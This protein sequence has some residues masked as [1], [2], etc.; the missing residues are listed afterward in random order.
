MTHPF[1]TYIQALGKGRRGSRDLS[2][3]E[4]HEAMQMILRRQVSAEQIG[5]FLMLMRIKEETPQELAGLV[6]A[7]R[8]EVKLPENFP[9]VDLDW[10]CYAGK[11]RQLPWLALSVMLLAQRGIKV[12]LHGSHMPGRIGVG[13][14]LTSL[15]IETSRDC[16]D[17]A[18]QLTN[19]NLAYLPLQ[20]LSPQLQGLLELKSTLG[21]RSPVNSV[22]R[23]LNPAGAET[24][25]IGIFHPGYDLAHQAAAELLGDKRSAVFKGEGG[26][27]ERN[28]D[29]DCTIRLLLDGVMHE[30]SWPAIFE[31]RHLKDESMDVGRLAK[32]WRGEI[33][34]E[35]A[36]S[37]V[38]ATAAIALRA[39]DKATDRSH[40]E[41]L[42]HEYWLARDRDVVPAFAANAA[43]A[44][45][46][47]VALVGAGPG[48]PELL[49]LRAL[50]LLQHADVV[51]YDNLVAPSILAMSNTN[52]ETI[53]VGKR[54]ANHALP[55]EQINEMLVRL[56]MQGKRVVRLKGG[57]PF[58]FGRGGEEIETLAEHHVPFE[59]VP[60]ITAASGVAAYAGIPLT[61][62]DH[63]QSCVFVTGHLKDGSMDLDW[64]A[65]S[66]PNQTIVVYMGLQGVATLCAQLV[67]HGMDAATPA[68]LVQQATTSNQRVLCATLATLPDIVEQE[69]PQAPT[70]I[71]VGGVVSLHEK[72]CWYTQIEERD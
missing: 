16:E 37:A 52:A 19:R 35:Y 10:G 49:T 9:K 61:H 40:A 1:A 54:R 21:L 29:S 24:S 6:R 36:R 8:R 43:P 17:A 4:A 31:H 7:A 39:M 3:A 71:I 62:R 70:L 30:E 33:E 65:L 5:A 27:A 28:P 41:Q 2:L 59:V 18:R 12:L 51:V 20:V 34:D 72:L 66:R 45:Q 14:V 69:K 60:G 25:M 55:Q 15:G 53:Y 58:I 32:F 22:V 11:R 68:A 44:V 42:A 26:E 56:A 63:A 47:R 64:D 13:D 50:S 67:S 48:D 46:G 38:L 23:M 57:D